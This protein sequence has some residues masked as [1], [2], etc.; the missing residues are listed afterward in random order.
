MTVSAAMTSLRLFEGGTTDFLETRRG[1][2]LG[3]L[4]MLCSP[5]SPPVVTAGKAAVATAVAAEKVETAAKEKVK[6]KGSTDEAV[7][8]PTR[9]VAVRPRLPAA[10]AAEPKPPKVVPP[11]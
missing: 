6:S 2:T 4:V 9:T 10:T 7:E 1:P 3:M 11:R 8:A 5:P